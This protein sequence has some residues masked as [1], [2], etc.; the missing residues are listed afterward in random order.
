MNGKVRFGD[1][2]GE[3]PL[4]SFHEA[5]QDRQGMAAPVRTLQDSGEAR[6]FDIHQ[7]EMG[8]APEDP[9]VVGHHRPGDAVHSIGREI[10]PGDVYG[11]EIAIDSQDPFRAKESAGNGQDARARSKIHHIS[12]PVPIEKTF[13]GQQTS[14]CRGMKARTEDQARID[15]ERFPPWDSGRLLGRTKGGNGEAAHLLGL[16]GDLLPLIIVDFVSILELPAL[17]SLHPFRGRLVDRG[18]EKQVIERRFRPN[19]QEGG[20][21]RLAGGQTRPQTFIDEKPFVDSALHDRLC[22]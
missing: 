12:N 20:V 6:P 19:T 1:Q 14:S 13:N 11:Q 17:L 15:E 18:P 8:R 3:L 10:V 7:E 4:L 9:R 21:G 2:L 5:A 16:R 22:C